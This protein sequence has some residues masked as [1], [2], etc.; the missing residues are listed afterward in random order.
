M[1]L[2]FNYLMDEGAIVYH[3]G[4]GRFSAD[5][6]KFKTAARKLTGEIMTIQAEGAFEKAKAM[7]DSYSSL[8]PVMQTCLGKLAELPVDIEPEFPPNR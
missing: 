6:G 7:I 1:A 8:R 5:I 2:Q 3:E 4:T